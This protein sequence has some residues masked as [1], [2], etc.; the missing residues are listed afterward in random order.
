MVAVGVTVAVAVAV[1]V[2]LG[3]ATGFAVAVAWAAE[4]ESNVGATTV[5]MGG[6]SLS[7]APPVPAAGVEMALPSL[8]G[9]TSLAWTL[10]RV[11]VGVPSLTTGWAPKWMLLAT[12]YPA[13]S[14]TTNI[15]ANKA[16]YDLLLLN[17]TSVH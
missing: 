7:P 4:P 2:L 8:E 17:L 16:A 15:R 5:G 10:P 1:G 13:T 11:G 14:A 9:V 3:P 6:C 12:M